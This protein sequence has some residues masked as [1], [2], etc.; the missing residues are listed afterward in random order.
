MMI[1]KQIF[2]SYINEMSWRELNVVD[3]YA[4]EKLKPID[5]EFTQHFFDRLNDPRNGKEIT[6]EEL[7]NFFTRLSKFKD[8]F[9]DV[10]DR[11]DDIVLKDKKTNINMALVK[12]AN[13]V[14]AKTI[15]RKGNF[16]THDHVMKFE[17]N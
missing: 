3:K 7:T 14:I 17:S 4:D 1:Y 12:R 16:K 5:V 8:K 9:K 11:Y 10:M 15:M 6:V 13:E 2:E